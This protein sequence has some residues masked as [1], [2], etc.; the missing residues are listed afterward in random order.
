MTKAKII[1]KRL[2]EQQ[3]AEMC[4]RYQMGDGIREIARDFNYDPA[5]LQKKFKKDELV[6]G[7]LLHLIDKKTIVAAESLKTITTD[8]LQITTELQRPM[9]QHK[10]NER[11]AQ[12]LGIV[13][14]TTDIALRLNRDVLAEVSD[15][16][17]QDTANRYQPEQTAAILRVLGMTHDKL[18]E[19]TGIKGEN[20]MRTDNKSSSKPIVINFNPVKKLDG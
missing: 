1:T 12:W 16:S 5:N 20:L 14:G 13:E 8:I 7:E 3:Y 2:T 6:Q 18:L 10:L 19:Q 11:V 15:R 9:V 4:T 17:K